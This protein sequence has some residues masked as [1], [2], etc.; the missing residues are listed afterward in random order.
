MMSA[1]EYTSVLN[2]RHPRVAHKLGAYGVMV[3]ASNIC[4]CNFHC[5]RK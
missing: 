5:L 3:G 2:V 1:V 4:D